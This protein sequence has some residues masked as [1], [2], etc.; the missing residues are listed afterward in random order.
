MKHSKAS[1]LIAYT[2]V[3]LQ[4]RLTI[5]GSP[6]SKGILQFD[7]WNVVPKS[8]RYDWN[9]L[10]SQI[11]EHGMRNSLLVAPM[12]TASTAQILMNVECFEP[13]SSNIFA[14]MTLAGNCHCNC[15]FKQIVFAGNF[16][17]INHYLVD[18]L[19]RLCLWSDAMRNEIIANDGSIQSITSIPKDIRDLYK[20]VW[21]IKQRTIL[22]MAADRGPYI[23]QSQSLNIHIASPTFSMMSS[24]HFHGWKSG[25]KGSQYYLRTR[26]AADSIKFTVDT[27]TQTTT[28]ASVCSRDDPDCLSC[29]S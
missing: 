8:G 22:N 17:V 20:T 19:I 21:E 16:V 6:A 1:V 10:K 25:L 23:D 9:N 14:R 24:M 27:T 26:P 13:I 28:T 18:D 29:G 5:S 7:M 2:S 3:H 15:Y 4:H 11:V 12:P